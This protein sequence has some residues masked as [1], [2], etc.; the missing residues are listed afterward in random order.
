[1]S[2]PH[3]KQRREN[4]SCGIWVQASYINHSC[5]GNVRRSFLGDM[6]IIRAM[7]DIPADTELTFW[8]DNRDTTGYDKRQEKLRHWGFQCSCVMCMDEKNTPKKTLKRREALAADLTGAFASPAGV[9][10]AKVERLLTAL[11]RTYKAAAARVPRLG[12]WDLYRL[13]ARNYATRNEL[14]KLVTTTLKALASF[15]FVITGAE[16]TQSAKPTNSTGANATFVVEQWGL[17]DDCVFEAFLLLLKVY[18]DVAP[19]LYGQVEE[20]ARTAYRI[21]IGEDATF[22]QHY[23]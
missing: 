18:R 5:Y 3:G 8:Y 23:G 16:L 2:T 11:E 19:H 13:L 1:M 4:L 10:L 14:E 21:C 7:R 20:C 22:D 9:D 12:M 15:G 17:M 6:Q